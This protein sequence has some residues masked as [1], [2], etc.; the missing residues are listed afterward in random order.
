[1]RTESEIKVK[2]ESL[3][4]D[5]LLS[6]QSGDYLGVGQGAMIVALQWVLQQENTEETQ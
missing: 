1:M 2:L 6:V 4:E 3:Q 5:Y